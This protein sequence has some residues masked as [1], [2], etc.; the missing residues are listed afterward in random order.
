MN[1]FVLVIE[2]QR[3]YM[4]EMAFQY[5]FTAKQTVKAS[6]HLDKLLNLVQHSEIWKYLAEDDKNRYESA[7][8]M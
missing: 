8:V 7:L 6:Q 2:K 4:M 3:N 5:G 1:M